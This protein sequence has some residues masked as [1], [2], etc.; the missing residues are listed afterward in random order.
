MLSNVM[1]HLPLLLVVATS[2]GVIAYLWRELQRTKEELR[3]AAAAPQQSAVAEAKRQVRFVQ[4]EADAQPKSILKR[5]SYQDPARSSAGDEDREDHEDHEDREGRE[6]REGYED[7]EASA[8]PAATAPP[9]AF[10]SS[11]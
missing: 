4:V 10:E 11:E 1:P 6:G 3:A 5:T 8:V 2:L 9:A 7:D